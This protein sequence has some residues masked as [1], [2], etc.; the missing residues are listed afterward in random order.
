VYPIADNPSG[1][2]IA[3]APTQEDRL[4]RSLRE[5][6]M[7]KRA[8]SRYV[9]REVVDEILNDPEQTGVS[10]ERRDVTVLFCDIRGLTATAETLPPEAVV[11]L[12]NAFY[13]LM[14]E[15]TFKHDGTLDTFLGDGVMAVFGAPLYRPDHAVMAARTALAMQAAVRELSARRAAAGQVPLVVGIGLNAGEVIAGTSAPTRAWSTRSWAT[16]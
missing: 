8:F 16:A 7:I 10:G 9:A 12:L 5:K 11:E 4:A 6:E 2:K 1:P 14:I 15:S 13:D 3:T